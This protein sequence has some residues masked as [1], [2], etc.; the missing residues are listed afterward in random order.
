LDWIEP[1]AMTADRA[2][3]LYIANP[4]DDEIDVINPINIPYTMP[5]AA[6]TADAF[7]E[8]DCAPT[9][10]AVDGYETIYVGDACAGE[11][12]TIYPRGGS[13]N[14][15]YSG[16]ASINGGNLNDP[17]GIAVN[18]EGT[19]VYVADSDNNVIQVYD[20]DLNWLSVIGDIAGAS[21][22]VTGKF[23]YP[24]GLAIDSDGNLLVVDADNARIQKFSPG[25]TFLQSFGNT[26]TNISN[27]EL[28]SP[29]E[30]ALDA[31]KDI[32]ITDENY[33]T[34]FKYGSN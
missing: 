9:A 19:T 34:V 10:V 21:G 8:G 24:A 23:D 7:Y 28:Y 12:Y 30:L 25:G 17:Y 16:S 4:N 11:I 3:L 27:G 22:A 31:N 2:G 26:A 33:E 18:S 29:L 20:G 32:F 15:T 1:Y 14:Y 13:G 5:D 6:V